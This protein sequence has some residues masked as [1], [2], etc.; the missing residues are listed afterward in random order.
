MA[1][2]PKSYRKFVATAATATLVASA[3]TPAF[4]AE[5]GAAASFSDVPER[6]EAAVSYLVD[7]KITLGLT[8]ETFGTQQSIKRVDAAVMIA[9]ALEINIDDA[10]DSGFTDVPDRAKAYVDALKAEG[11]INGLSAT[12]FGSEQEITRGQMA[13]IIAAAYELT[14]DKSNLPFTDVSDRY[15]EA[16]AAL[17]DNNITQGTSATSFGTGDAI[18]RGDFA[19]FLYRAETLN[20]LAVA[21]VDV[22]VQD[23]KATVTANVKNA[24][25]NATAKVEIF[26]NGGSTAATEKTVSVVDGKVT[27]NFEN[28]PTGSHVAKVTVNEVSS[29]TSFTVAAPAIAEVASVTALNSKQVE[30][31]FNTAVKKESVVAATT[32]GTEVK[33]TLVNNSITFT[34][35]ENPAVNVLMNDAEAKLSAD[36]KTLTLTI[37]PGAQALDGRYDVKVAEGAIKTAD[38][39]NFAKF[40]STINVDDTTAPLVIS[41]EKVTASQVKVTFSEPVQT[42]GTVTY[43]LADGTVVN[44]GGTGVNVVWAE[45]NTQAIFSIGSDVAANKEVIATIIGAQDYQ[46][47]LLS[48]NPATVTLYKGDKDGVK[49]TVSSVNVINAKKFE[50]KFSEELQTAPTITVS[51]TPGTLT[52][53]QDK[54]DKTKYVVE[55]TN[56][57]S[58]LQTVSVA[59]DANFKDLSGEQGDAYSKV[60]NFS[61][62]TVAPKLMS[63]TVVAVDNVQ[64]LELNFD[65]AVDKLP[66]LNTLAVTGS[67][68]KDFVTTAVNVTVPVAQLVTVTDNEKVLRVKLSDLLAGNDVEGAVYDLTVTGKDVSNA[69]VAI[70]EDKSGNDGI[71]N[72][73]PSFTRGKDGNPSSL[74][75]ATI[76]TTVG[77]NGVLENADKTVT[78][79]FNQE[80]DG[81]TATNI[82]NYKID[83]AVVEKAVLNPVAG[84]KQTV[85]LT[86]K[87]ES[88]LFTGVRNVTI[89]GVKAKSGLVM[90]EYKTTE[91][92]RENVSPTVTKSVLTAPDQVTLTFSEAVTNATAANDFELLIGGVKVTAND[93]VTTEIQSTGDTTLVLTLEDDLT[94]DDL[95]KGVQLKALDTIDVVDT[96]DNKVSIPANI[97]IQQ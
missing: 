36:G 79:A 23:Q 92:L 66:A 42:L 71:T 69:T 8:P 67:K 24:P 29:Q 38:D 33:D 61:V 2:Q 5:T 93:A 51:G 52:I 75:R 59:S 84:G 10:P 96:A 56:V 34:S 40:S 83:G 49:P 95:A 54:T 30:I 91:T 22:A 87:D 64:Y 7:N 4:A 19:I 65:E 3:V 37:A 63:S 18:K 11:L 21:D 94:A 85:T 41:T 35:I 1:Y 58:N 17:V 77:A 70:V 57:I 6:Y 15:D 31:K 32:A 97:T 27:A 14:G 76:D 12:D 47:N 44:S 50:V 73:K 53:T 90:E 62:D 20:V 74:N 28:L 89:S 16:V 39:K 43:K 9:K 46:G 82:N 68:V 60:V 48:P 25:E 86:I 78:V 55:T 45:N 80:L 81:A 88:N 72:F 26:A 13:L